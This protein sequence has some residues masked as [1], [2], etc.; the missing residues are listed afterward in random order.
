M[1]QRQ[2]FL[3]AIIADPDDDAVRLIYA[4]WLE[5]HGSAVERDRAR[6]IRLQIELER[7]E[8]DDRRKAILDEC[9]QLIDRHWQ[10]WTHGFQADRT[11]AYYYKDTYKRG[12]LPYMCLDDED[13]SDPTLDVLLAHEPITHFF[14]RRIDTFPEAVVQWKHLPRVQQLSFSGGGDNVKALLRSPLLTGLHVF[15]GSSVLDEEEVAMIASDPRFADL[16][17][18]EIGYS[19]LGDSAVEMVAQSRTLSHL[20]A[21]DY[22]GNRTTIAA[23]QAVAGSPL[24]GRL[25]FIGL[26]Q[27]DWGEA[28]RVGSRAAELLADFRCLQG[29]DLHGQQIRDEGAEYLARSSKLADLKLL[30]LGQNGLGLRGVT[31][32][33]SSPYLTK[34]EELDLSNNRPGGDWIA[35]LA[36]ADARRFRKLSL[37]DNQ[38]NGQVAV[39]LADAAVLEGVRE[40]SL[41]RNPVGDQGAVA[42]AGSARLTRLR[43]LGLGSCDIG[44]EGAIALPDSS[45]LGKLEGFGGLGL[46]HNRYSGAA[47]HRL[48]KRFGYDPTSY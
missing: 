4:D 10:E 6:F 44:D 24:A 48:Q 8:D 16:R 39:L 19:D 41:R 47:A 34:V 3:D 18:L 35:A 36:S 29:I 28:P 7:V 9:N 22:S 27:Y 26:R 43:K 46:S 33:L 23:L 45:S 31:A 38:L 42:L 20:T 2:A 30:Q 5:E 1:D 12:F 37:E 17:R 32:L 40:L 21:F 14:M 11:A 25:T 15:E 13:L